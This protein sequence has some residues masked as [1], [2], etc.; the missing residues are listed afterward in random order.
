MVNKI[1]I[2]EFKSKDKK[3]NIKNVGKLEIKNFTADRAELYF[4]GDIVSSEWGK[5]E[6]ADKC[7]ED[8]LN[9]FK[10]VEEVA[11]LDIYIN[12]GGGS[13]FAG[14]SIYNILKRNKAFKTVYVD[15]L[16]GSIASVIA[17]SGDKLVI[18]SNA[19]MMIH[20]AWAITWGNSNEL[21]KMADDLDKI[22]EGILNV[23]E[24]NIKDGVDIKTIKKMVDS[25]TWLTGKDV[26]NYF[27]VEVIEENKVVACTSDYF[28]DYSNVPLTLKVKNVETQNEVDNKDLKKAK[29]KLLLL[30]EI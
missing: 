17:F 25:E 20:K 9:F 13:V 14:M 8:V 29:A 2:L 27:E 18:P 28:K 23:Y 1:K 6:D 5:W 24:A 7:P 10:E 15:G 22:D 26:S 11:E 3:G 12:S 4:Y 30:A 16:A 21:R 19:Y